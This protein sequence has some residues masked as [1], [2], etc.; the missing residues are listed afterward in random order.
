MRL[1]KKML[2]EKYEM[3]LGCARHGDF[4]LGQSLCNSRL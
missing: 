3:K 4:L 2:D 1:I